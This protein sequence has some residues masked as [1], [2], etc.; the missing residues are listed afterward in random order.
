MITYEEAFEIAKERKDQIDNCTEYE[1]A[2]VFS[3][4]GDGNC[5][6]GYGRTPVVIMK[7]NGRIATLPELIARGTGEEIRSFN[8]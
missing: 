6:G 3:Y 8:I 4:T 7:E 2:Y 1:N 5:R